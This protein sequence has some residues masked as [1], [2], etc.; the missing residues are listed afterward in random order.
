MEYDDPHVRGD[1]RG[2]RAHIM[3]HEDLH[4]WHAHVLHAESYGWV[5][6]SPFEGGGAYVAAAL[7]V[8]QLV[9]IQDSI[10]AN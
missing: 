4:H 3:E 9:L 8:A 5:F 10:T 1:L 6:T 2:H 7:Q